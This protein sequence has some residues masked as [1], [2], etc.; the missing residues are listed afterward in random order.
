MNDGTFTTAVSAFVCA[1]AGAISSVPP[2]AMP[3]AIPNTRNDI[4]WC[5]DMPTTPAAKTAVCQAT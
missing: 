4:F 5:A 1:V 3:A 2:A